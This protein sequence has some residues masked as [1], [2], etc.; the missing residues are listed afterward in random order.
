MEPA[1]ES[2]CDRR[3]AQLEAQGR[4]HGEGLVFLLYGDEY[5]CRQ[6]LDALL[7][8]VFRGVAEAQ[9]DLDRLDGASV[10]LA[11]ALER[12]ATYS[13]LGGPKVV[14]LQEPPL[15]GPRQT[16]AAALQKAREAYAA[17]DLRKAGRS[18]R[19]HMADSGMDPAALQDPERQ[20]A[21]ERLSDNPGDWDWILALAAGGLLAQHAAADGPGQAEALEKALARGFPAGHHLVLLTGTVD[22]RAKLLR[23]IEERGVVL[24]LSL[25]QGERRAERGALQAVL[26]GVAD[27][28]LAAAGKRLEPQGFQALCD[29]CGHELRAFTVELRKLVDF[30]GERPTLTAADVAAL[31]RK[32][33]SDPIYQL[34][35]AVAERDAEKAL[36]CLE[37]MLRQDTEGAL[38]PL[39]VLSALA[40]QM[41]RLLAAADCLS[42]AAGSVF[43]PGMRYDAFQDQVLPLL[44]RYDQATLDLCQRWQAALA[45]PEPAGAPTGKGG[46]A[47]GSKQRS[48]SA[49]PAAAEA[50]V[51]RHAGSP[52]PTFLLLRNAARF[53]RREFGAIFRQLTRAER[54]LKGGGPDP[55][56]T[57]SA[58]ILAICGGP[59]S[60]GEGAR[61][62]DGEHRSSP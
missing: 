24:D 5:L 41:R 38:H 27:P 57:L 9:R 34:T 8:R 35:G 44:Q 42:A 46:G 17:G 43:R 21:L 16:A 10:P 11:A 61:G 55:A 54:Q 32:T 31:V 40:N 49:P 30:A 51:A 13:L 3:L 4:L 60:A 56:L 20:S 23:R 33:R 19:L 29:I 58:L 37:A 7:Q 52:Y 36:R 62:A 39:Q 59:R 15:F 2:P 1:A 28:I 25:P 48:R 18:L 50:L 14:V 45:E 12:V 6:A 47:A 26:R 53:D 22:R